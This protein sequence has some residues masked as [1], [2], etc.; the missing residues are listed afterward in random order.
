RR[1]VLRGCDVIGMTTNGAA[2]F[3]TLIRSIGPRIIICEEAGEVLAAHILSSLTPATQHMILIGDHNQA[4]KKI[5]FDLR[6]HCAT[7]SLTC[8]S[9]VG[10]NYALDKS[11]FERLVNGDQA[12][13]LEKSQ[14]CTQRRMR[15]EI[16]DLIRQTL[17]EELVDNENTVSYPDVRGAQRNVYFMD[18]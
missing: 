16:S 15:G 5:F 8:D 2:K 14:L 4:Y 18:H 10:C 13:R 17:Y 3:Q 12:M 7:Y 1:Q 6:P 9:K 11:L